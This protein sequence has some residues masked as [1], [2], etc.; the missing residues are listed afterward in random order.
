MSNP[1]LN[2]FSGID[3][4]DLAELPLPTS[5]SMF[6]ET[7][8]WKLLVLT[9]LLLALAVS[10]YYWHRYQRRL[11]RRQAQELASEAELSGAA[12]EWFVLIKR[13]TRLHLAADEFLS[14]SDSQLLMQ[15]PDLAEDARQA[16]LRQ[17]YRRE[18]TLSSQDNADVADAFRRWLKELSDV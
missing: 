5:V 1:Q 12:D 6:P 16:L 7:L 8:A 2:T 11:W 14:L 18:R 10:F 17:H 9:L 4:P 13:V 3:M 15:L